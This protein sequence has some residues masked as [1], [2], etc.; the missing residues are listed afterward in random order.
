[1]VIATL[2]SLLISLVRTQGMVRLLD[3][4]NHYIWAGILFCIVGTY[5][6]STNI[7]TVIVMLVSGVIGLAMKRAGF[8]AGP[9]VLGLL[10]G[11]LAE[12]N[13]RRA[14]LIDGP[15]AFLT[16]PITV[17]LLALTVLAV[18]APPLPQL[19]KRR[20][21]AANVEADSPVGPLVRR[22]IPQYG[23]AGSPW[24]TAG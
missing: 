8:P 1:M 14:L 15:E 6:T 9:V 19:R 5:T 2:L 16:R 4:P 11:P 13:L 3:L 23:V 24:T 12:V 22:S 10:L 20:R 17:T 21:A 7:Y 18:A